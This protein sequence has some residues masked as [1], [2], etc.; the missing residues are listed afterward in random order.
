MAR[1]DLNLPLVATRDVA[2]TAARLLTDKSW[3]QQGGVAVLGPEDLSPLDMADIMSD[4]L[5]RSIHFQQVSAE[6][7][8]AQLMRSGAS[9]AFAQG[10]ID[11]SAE[12]SGGLYSSVP[13]TSENTTPTSF[14]QWCEEV[15]RPAVQR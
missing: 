13:R 12:I 11:M 3:T 9:E 2:T 4:V 5:G 1:P 6:D 10:M 14:Y 15:L 7:Y 8:R